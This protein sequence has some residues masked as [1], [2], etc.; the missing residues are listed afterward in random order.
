MSRSIFISSMFVN[1]VMYKFKKIFLVILWISVVAVVVIFFFV[2][3]SMILSLLF[4]L[5]SLTN[6]LSILL[7]IVNEISCVQGGMAIDLLIFSKSQLFVSRILCVI[8]LES[9]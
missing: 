8:C 5:V 2:Y 1:L 3:K 7:I 9:I 4:C 6:S